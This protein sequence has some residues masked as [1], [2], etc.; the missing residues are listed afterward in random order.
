MNTNVYERQVEYLRSRT[1]MVDS[2]LQHALIPMLS[3]TGTIER[4]R[5][6]VFE[7]EYILAHNPEWKMVFKT[8]KI[9][10]KKNGRKR[11]KFT[12]T[13]TFTLKNGE[14]LYDFSKETGISL[15][16]LLFLNPDIPV[17][18][19]VDGEYKEFAGTVIN[20]D[21]PTT[22]DN[23][24]KYD[25]INRFMVFIDG[26][27]ISMNRTSL[28]TDILN[29]FIIVDL[30][31]IEDLSDINDFEKI[32][33]LYYDNATEDES[34]SFG[35][36]IFKFDNRGCLSTNGQNKVWTSDP[37]LY[38]FTFF[39]DDNFGKKF[40]ERLRP[41]TFKQ[42]IKPQNIFTFQM[43]QLL[44]D[45]PITVHNGNV[46]N[47]FYPE[48]KDES[49]IVVFYNARVEYTEDNILRF[50][51]EMLDEIQDTH[52]LY[53]QNVESSCERFI[54]ELYIM[55]ESDPTDEKFGFI[56]KDIRINAMEESATP[57]DTLIFYTGAIT[58]RALKHIANEVFKNDTQKIKDIMYKIIDEAE[59]SEEKENICKY[60]WN[61]RKNLP[62]MFK[63]NHPE[64]SM[65]Y[66][67][68]FLLVDESFNFWHQDTQLYEQNLKDAIK[69]ISEYD[70]DKLESKLHRF[71]YTIPYLGKD[72]RKYMK[73]DILSMGR[74]NYN[75][76]KNYVMIFKN[77]EL[78]DSYNTIRYDY[79][80]FYVNMN[81]FNDDDKFDF[82]FFLFC[83]N[84]LF[85]MKCNNSMI[86][87]RTVFT[88]YE[89]QFFDNKIR[90]N[91]YNVNTGEQVY[92]V[93]F[94]IDLPWVMSEERTSG[95]EPTPDEP[96][97]GEFSVMVKPQVVLHFDDNDTSIDNY[98]YISSDE[99]LEEALKIVDKYIPEEGESKDLFIKLV[100][101]SRYGR[102]I[103]EE[104]ALRENLSDT[105]SIDENGTVDKI[106]Q[107]ILELRDAVGMPIP[108][109]DEEE[110]ET[111]GDG[112]ASKMVLIDD[113]ELYKLK[114][115][116]ED[117]AFHKKSDVI[118]CSK[119][120]FRYWNPEIESD[121]MEYIVLD[122]RF[123]YCINQSQF[124]VFVNHRLL[125]KTYIISTPLKDTPVGESRLYF[126]I[127]IHTTDIL[128][129]FY[130]SDPLYL[131][132]N[133]TLIPKTDGTN[134]GYVRINKSETLVGLNKDSALVFVNGKK[135]SYSDILDVSNNTIKILDTNTSKISMTKSLEIY[136]YLPSNADIT[137][138]EYSPSLLD[139]MIPANPDKIDRGMNVVGK[140]PKSDESE[141][142][143]TRYKDAVREILYEDYEASSIDDSWLAFF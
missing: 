54:Q 135:I 53:I 60:E 67:D 103:N 117:L 38:H 23:L 102:N 11:S 123:K 132:F 126:N 33:L 89:V 75:H 84:T 106:I 130:V 129:I 16:T 32:D 100:N 85:P 10:Y 79:M 47:I 68:N 57:I 28:I 109:P 58:N 77:G 5:E 26:H 63:Y 105:L 141:F 139:E 113:K 90:G 124:L 94:E 6:Y 99:T 138:K 143:F 116:E 72:L 110:P 65:D 107:D 56:F 69:Y 101:D 2:A 131:D 104:I 108:D 30:R 49:K 95:V 127:E 61:L 22:I 29:D 96:I 125:P 97:S 93:P 51:S 15:E 66:L 137:L 42:K 20:T 80:N 118:V 40:N 115:T 88:P 78:L 50:N 136:R 37:L 91:T 120:Q 140:E 48:F 111:P 74:Y 76:R 55:K 70:S 12:D 35:E 134:S 36:P 122:E 82:V 18:S 43:G 13:I 24:A 87:N 119:R 86:Q 31:S 34:E 4:V 112:Q 44:T 98:I 81:E 39:S 114:M 19:M 8:D 17:D 73:K 92:S 14:T 1:D 7:D 59:Y 83:N 121:G 133:P 62:E 64:D 3:T 25:V 128:E 71:V 41:F 9:L 27:Y 21:I 45:V 52:T 46:V 142:F